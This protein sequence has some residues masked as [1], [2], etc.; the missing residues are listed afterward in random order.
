[1]LIYKVDI[2]LS[3]LL[4]IL[5]IRKNK[6][7]ESLEQNASFVLTL[8]LLVT[9]N[10]PCSTQRNETWGFESYH[11]GE[12]FLTLS[13][14]YGLF[15]AQQPLKFLWKLPHSLCQYFSRALGI[16]CSFSV[17]T[18]VETDLFFILVFSKNSLLITAT[19]IPGVSQ[20][21]VLPEAV[22]IQLF[23]FSTP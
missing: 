11:N 20:V 19:K 22:S 16:S 7:D 13:N 8:G 2:L 5:Y 3:S 1:M 15:L 17:Q 14:L 18:A 9:L 4:L 12:H 21:P 23:F 6:V 10:F